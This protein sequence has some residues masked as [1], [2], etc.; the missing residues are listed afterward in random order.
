MNCTIRES[1]KLCKDLKKKF[2]KYC[3][4]SIHFRF[5]D[6]LAEGISVYIQDFEF[7]N[8]QNIKDARRHYGLKA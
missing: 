8:F 2:G 4:V 1:R 5:H 7:E 3:H 6:K